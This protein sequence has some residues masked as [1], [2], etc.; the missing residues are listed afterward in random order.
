[1]IFRFDSVLIKS[2]FGIAAADY[3]LSTCILSLDWI[4]ELMY[5]WLY[6]II[7]VH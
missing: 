3:I 4:Y 2:E 6:Y 5:F 7:I 1:M